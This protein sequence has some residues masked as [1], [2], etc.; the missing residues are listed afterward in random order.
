MKNCGTFAAGVRELHISL[1]I[2]LKAGVRGYCR[3]YLLVKVCLLRC[4]GDA[5]GMPSAPYRAVGE[6]HTSGRSVCAHSV[7]RTAER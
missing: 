4:T 1:I 5:N 2:L 7:E 3:R 6:P